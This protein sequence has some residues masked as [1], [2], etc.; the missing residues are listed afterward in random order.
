MI[1]ISE[2]QRDV[3]ECIE[4]YV[5]MHKVAPTVSEIQELTGMA[6]SL[7]SRRLDALEQKRYIKRESKKTRSI[8]VIRLAI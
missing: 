4:E 6:R 7:V 2:K 3:L 5:A 1:K 8:V